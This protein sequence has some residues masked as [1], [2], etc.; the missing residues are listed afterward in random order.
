[1]PGAGD[2]PELLYPEAA[3]ELRELG[4]GSTLEYVARAA[5][6]VLADTGL[7]PHVNAGT[8]GLAE[9]HAGR[10]F[11]L[12]DVVQAACLKHASE[13]SGWGR[14]YLHAGY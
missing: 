12:D 2:K 6:A 13:T 4:C 5:A 10:L 3:R 7:L 11:L 9:V 8:M 1:M 14:V